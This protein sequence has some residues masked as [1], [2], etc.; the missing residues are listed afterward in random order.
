[1]LA[2]VL[3]AVAIGLIPAA[4]AS[5]KGRSFVLWWLFGAAL[6]IVALPCALL[7]SSDRAALDRRAIDGEGL[8]RCPACA[9]LVRPEAR[10][11]RYCA[12]ALTPTGA[13]S[14][15]GGEGA[16]GTWRF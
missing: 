3:I 12:A 14:T 16:R 8:R 4:I 11:C 15:A 5:A 10:V 7:A 13:P 6:F 9:E 1:M 2:V